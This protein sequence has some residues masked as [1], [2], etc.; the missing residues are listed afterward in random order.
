MDSSEIQSLVR[1]NTADSQFEIEIDGRTAFTMYR[2]KPGRIILVHTEVPPELKGHGV[3]NALARVSL[4]YAR[5]EKL[6]VIPRCPFIS[7]F[8]RRHP[9][10]ED[11]VD[12]SLE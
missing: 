5:D 3:G 12:E 8:I 6:Q 2:L 11:L 4:D 10:Y 9:E 7:T 1:N